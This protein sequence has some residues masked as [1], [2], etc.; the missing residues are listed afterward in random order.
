VP[1]PQSSRRSR[2]AIEENVADGVVRSALLVGSENPWLRRHV[3]TLPFVHRAVKRFMPGERLADAIA[4]TIDLQPS[5]IGTVLTRLGENITDAAAAEETTRHYLTVCS[6]VSARSLDSHISVKLTQLGLDIDAG[7]CRANLVTLAEETKRR[8]IRL[9]IDMEQSSY[10]DR[11][12]DMRR[13]LREFDHVGVCLQAYL[14]RTAEDLASLMPLGGG[15]RLVKGA[16]REPPG[17]AFPRKADVDEHYFTLA[18]RLLASHAS[19]RSVFGTHD[20]RLIERI[21]QHARAAAVPLDTFEFHLLFG[22]QR[23]EQVRL[24]REGH[25]VK[26]L[27]SYGEQW[28]PWYMRRLAERPANLAFVAKSLFSR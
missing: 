3:S 5:G 25:G 27:I 16:Y 1:S 13:A 12:L 19:L 2:T 20:A 22:I 8:G 7:R 15:I 4:A 26:V 23:A 17:V 28:F 14:H 21:R 24:A 18:A 11:T 9:W 10:V 6:E